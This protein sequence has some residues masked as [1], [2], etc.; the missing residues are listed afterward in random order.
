MQSMDIYSFYWIE[1]HL[2]ECKKLCNNDCKSK[3]VYV[4]H[5]KTSVRM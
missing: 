2:R 1:Q 5:V 4:K 3:K